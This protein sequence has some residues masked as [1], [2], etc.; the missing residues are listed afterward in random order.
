MNGLTE[1]L[2][3]IKQHHQEQD[4]QAIKALEHKWR[5]GAGYCVRDALEEAC[6][7]L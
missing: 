2:A 7:Q 1:E 6:Q 3:V 4:W 5:G